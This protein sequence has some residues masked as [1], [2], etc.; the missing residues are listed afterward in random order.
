MPLAYVAGKLVNFAHV[1]RCAGSAVEDYLFARF[2]PLG[3][4][5]RSHMSIPSAERWS[6]SSP[7]HITVK[8]FERLVPSKWIAHSFAIVRHPEDRLV[9]VFRFQRDVEQS[10]DSS[11]IFEDW[12]AQLPDQHKK[13]PYTLDNH[14]LPAVELVPQ[15]ATVFKLEDGLDAVVKWL[16][17]LEA[18]ARLPREILPKNS[19]TLR[20]QQASRMPR[21]PVVATPA[22]RQIILELYEL[23]FRRFGYE[24]HHT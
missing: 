12:V 15:A 14:T 8:S 24:P 4:L 7:Q 9:S 22:V 16:D 19:Y 5:D 23:D 11:T 17:D 3:F 2:G 21:V 20:M 13:S 10:I 6:N 18:T 1:P